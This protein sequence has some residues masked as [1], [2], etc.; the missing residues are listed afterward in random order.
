MREPALL[1]VSQGDPSGIG[2][3]ITLAAWL[4]RRAD[5]P[6]FV[7]GDPALYIARARAIGLTISVI[8]T[9]SRE[10]AAVFNRGLPVVATG[11]R[12][13]GKPGMPVVEDAAGTIAAIDAAVAA[14]RDGLAAAVVT[15]PI[16]KHVLYAAGFEHPGHTEYLGA[17]A[18]ASWGQIAHPVMMLWSEQ[19]AVVPITIH[20]AL[21]AVPPLITADLIIRTARTVRD[22]LQSLFGITEPR[23]VCA[24]LN[25][26]AGEDGS[27]GRE[28]IEIIG[29]ALASLRA[30]G[31]SI[32]GPLSADTMF[33]PAAR[34][35]YDAALTMYHDQGLI[36]IKT[37]SFD[38]GVNVTLGL[39]FI[40]TSPD[41]G[42]AFGIAGQGVADPSS[43]IAALALARRM[44]NHRSAI[45]VS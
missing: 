3:D 38:T 20:V 41:H 34:A 29:P 39:P 42:T 22:A 24:G 9:D 37:L 12:V 35:R 16:A 44:S 6:F 19:L 28:E 45:A 1:A 11:W 5:A 8:E 33:H 18:R 13:V 31:F 23:L 40:R 4:R 25:P 7:F 15:N 14:V 30:D 10:A 21:K 32:D 36:P 26:H 27:M 2:P 17:L 43:L